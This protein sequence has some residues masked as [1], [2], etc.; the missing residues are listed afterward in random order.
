[1]KRLSIA[2]FF[3]LVMGC[4]HEPRVLYDKEILFNDHCPRDCD[5]KYLLGVG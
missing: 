2:V 3:L 4:Y 1:M 5:A